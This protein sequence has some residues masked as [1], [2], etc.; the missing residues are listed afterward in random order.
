MKFTV[1]GK[2]S[3]LIQS[4][5]V[6]LYKNYPYML[7]RIYKFFDPSTPKTNEQILSGFSDA[8]E[9]SFYFLQG[10]I[11]YFLY[12]RWY[13]RWV[14]SSH[15]QRQYEYR[16]A[17]A[18]KSCTLTGSCVCCGCKTPAL[19]FSDKGCSVSKYKACSDMGMS[20]CYPEMMSEKD[21]A[22]FNK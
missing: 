15:I 12:Q 11:R 1:N 5:V 2:L 18:N 3:K 16:L 6:F 7:I 9:D 13:L 21:W 8:P 22:E 17:V 20:K 10:N 19:Y 14:I 4:L